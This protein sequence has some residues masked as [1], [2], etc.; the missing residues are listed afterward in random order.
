MKE[1]ILAFNDAK[2]LETN[3]APS[4][5]IINAYEAVLKNLYFPHLTLPEIH[6]WNE[7]CRNLVELYDLEGDTEK[8]EHYRQQMRAEEGD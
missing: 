8:A 3:G 6:V 4:A 1:W 5:A 7:A 2:V